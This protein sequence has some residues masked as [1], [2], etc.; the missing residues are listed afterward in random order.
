ML[1]RLIAIG[2]RQ[3]AGARARSTSTGTHRRILIL[4]LDIGV[5]IHHSGLH[6]KE[7][8]KLL[9]FPRP[10]GEL[11]HYAALG[12]CLCPGWHWRIFASLGDHNPR[13]GCLLDGGGRLGPLLHFK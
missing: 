5:L 6:E 4:C 13:G 7:K 2:T 8:F 12:G 9:L 3:A 10:V 1:V 11:L